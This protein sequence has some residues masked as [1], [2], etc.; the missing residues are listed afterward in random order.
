[1]LG[2]EQPVVVLRLVGGCRAWARFRFGW[3]GALPAAGRW[4]GW[5]G[6]PMTAV[7]WG[8]GR[9]LGRRIS[10]AWLHLV[11]DGCVG[12]VGAVDG[13]SLAV[14][15]EGR[16]GRSCGGL[17]GLGVGLG[18]EC[19]CARGLGWRKAG[20]VGRSVAAVRARF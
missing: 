15:C 5:A 1:M 6:R 7:K 9:G 11:G 20:W 2:P 10:G 8:K 14:G 13:L 18:G 16:I 3:A 4:L 17:F 19:D 12:C